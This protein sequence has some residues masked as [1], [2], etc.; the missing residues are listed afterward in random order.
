MQLPQHCPAQRPRTPPPGL[1]T[2]RRGRPEDCLLAQ[3]KSH[4]CPTPGL[5]TNSREEAYDLLQ[6]HLPRS[7]PRSIFRVAHAIHAVMP[8]GPLLRLPSLLLPL[9]PFRH[10]P[11]TPPLMDRSPEVAPLA[12]LRR[13][14]PAG[15]AGLPHGCRKDTA[16]CTLALQAA[17]VAARAPPLE[18][19]PFTRLARRV[20]AG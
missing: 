3:R 7:A 9:W 10:W 6:K 19:S 15:A 2:R 16:L 20:R 11:F 5:P 1:Q 8:S 4:T 17:A 12:P 13:Y 18:P 14:C